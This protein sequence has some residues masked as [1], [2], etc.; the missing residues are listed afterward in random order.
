MGRNAR[1]GETRCDGAGDVRGTTD[2][3][4]KGEAG[5]AWAGGI[6]LR[7]NA[8]ALPQLP[9][10]KTGWP[11]SGTWP[12]VAATMP[13]GARW[14]RISIVT[15]SLN[16]GQYIEETIRSVLLQGYPNLEYLVKD[17]GSGDRTREVLERY[18]AWLDIVDVGPDGG[19][20]AAIA[21]GFSKS[22][23]EILAWLNADDLYL[24][25]T[26]ERVALFFA[27][28]PSCVFACG[29]VRL[30][31]PSSAPAGLLLAMET[32]LLL[33]KNTGSHG[34]WQP[35]TFW[36]RRAY[37]QCGGID[38]TFEFCMDRDLFVRLCSAG[39]SGR[40]S[41]PPLAAFRRHDEQKSHTMITTFEREH[42]L[43]LSR[44]GD[45][46]LRRHQIALT[47]LWQLWC[48]CHRLRWRLER[49]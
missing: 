44:Y 16:Q 36:R 21:S 28:R 22:N 38:S 1:Q 39:S 14:P 42:E 35:G 9:A 8:G 25:G 46:R 40:I 15:P 13:A 24:P 12:R 47:R 3:S 33:T 43:L 4:T 41:G 37:E 34:W 32:Q 20:A 5:N 48:V 23:G 17:G 45:P 31:S 26:L 30:I 19:Q 10:E 2:H 11:W 18:G 27:K 7:Q 29:D 49:A 6:S